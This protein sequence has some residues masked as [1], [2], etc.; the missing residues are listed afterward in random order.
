MKS[1]MTSATL[2][3]ALF[4]VFTLTVT[5]S[6]LAV[7]AVRINNTAANPVPV[8]GTMGISGIPTVKIQSLP[9]VSLDP[10]TPLTVKLGDAAALFSVPLFIEQVTAS[11]TIAVMPVTLTLAAPAVL[12]RVSADC[13]GRLPAMRLYVDGGPLGVNGVTGVAGNDV[14]LVVGT[15]AAI[16]IGVPYVFYPTTSPDGLSSHLPVS[17]IGTPVKSGIQLYLYPDTTTIAPQCFLNL[18]FR[19]I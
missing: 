5:P 9:P 14:G 13:G 3:A 18:V 7:D 1:T 10:A 17:P 12:E 4:G 6:A 2:T 15:L 11:P 8:T 19:S 16:P